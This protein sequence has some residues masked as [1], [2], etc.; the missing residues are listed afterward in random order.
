MTDIV[1]ILGDGAAAIDDRPLRWSLRSLEKFAT[2]VGR[3]VVCGRIPEW[4]SDEVVKVPSAE[5]ARKRG[6]GWNILYGY[7]DAVEGAGLADPFLYSSDDHY[8]SRPADLD[9]WPRFVNAGRMGGTLLKYGEYAAR[10]GRMPDLYQLSLVK[11]GDLLRENGL[12]ARDVAIH[13]NT[14]TDPQDV[15]P[16]IA[17]AESAK[18]RTRFGFEA[19][20]VLNALY[21]RRMAQAGETP[22]YASYWWDAK[23]SSAKDCADKVAKGLPGFSTTPAAERDARVVAWM[24]AFYNVPSKWERAAGGEGAQA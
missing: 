2:N 12:P 16:A 19:T 6:K 14:W 18:G 20:C 5:T 21:E 13:L 23:A 11:T 10:R 1:Y 9:K 15:A 17:L 4:L 24:D 7:R 22:V 3:V 8:L